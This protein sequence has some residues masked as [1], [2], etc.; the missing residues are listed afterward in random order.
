M[1]KDLKLLLKVY[2][3]EIK[4][5]SF[6]DDEACGSSKEVGKSQGSIGGQVDV[7]A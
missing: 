4:W 5:F 2:L 1:R 7:N 3:L 6:Q